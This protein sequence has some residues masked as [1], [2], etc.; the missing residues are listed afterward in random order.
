MAIAGT[1][2]DLDRD[3]WSAKQV[4]A[5]TARIV[6]RIGR[7]L[8]VRNRGRNE[9]AGFRFGRGYRGVGPRTASQPR[10]SILV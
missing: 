8:M 9:V 3:P 4:R 1:Q 2:P 7:G 5:G 10:P 6:R